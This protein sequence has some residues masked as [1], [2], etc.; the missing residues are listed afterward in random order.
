MLKGINCLYFKSYLEF[1]TEFLPCIIFDLSLF[2]YMI[3]LIYVKWSINWE[4]RMALGKLLNIYNFIIYLL[5]YIV[6]E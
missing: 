2:G 3:L 6:I 1:F 4:Q 5:Y